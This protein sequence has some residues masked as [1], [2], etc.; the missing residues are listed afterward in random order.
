MTKSLGSFMFR[1]TDILI[2]HVYVIMDFH[3][4]VTYAEMFR[5][6]VRKEYERISQVKA[7][8]GG[9]N[10]DELVVTPTGVIVTQGKGVEPSPMFR[11]V[12]IVAG[13]GK[14]IAD[15][16]IPD[17]DSDPTWRGLRRKILNRDRNRCQSCKVHRSYGRKMTVHH[18]VARDDGGNDDPSNL[19]TLCVPCH[20]LIEG[21]GLAKWEIKAGV[22][23]RSTK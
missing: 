19:I 17:S 5:G 6:I 18:I 10:S 2:R 22:T 9:S 8:E 1:K 4:Y 21:K 15:V 7:K 3:G 20:N 23:E 12:P 13:P 16:M 11:Q 14:P